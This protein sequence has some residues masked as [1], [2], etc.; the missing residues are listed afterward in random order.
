MGK[1][2]PVVSVLMVTYNREQYIDTALKSVL[3]QKTSFPFEIIICEDCSTDG[4]LAICE[5]YAKAYPEIIRLL[6]NEKNLGYQR[7]NLK[8]LSATRGKYIAVCDPDDYWICKDKLQ[9]QYDIMEKN[10]Q[11]SLCFHRVLNY[12]ENDGS[13]SLSNGTERKGIY[14]QLDLSKKNFIANVSCFF[15]NNYFELPEG[16]EQVVS[17]DYVFSMLSASK[18]DLYYIP[19][20]MALYRKSESSI[21]VGKDRSKALLMSLNVRKFIINLFPENK[22]VVDNLKMASAAILYNLWKL[23]KS[24]NETQKADEVWRELASEYPV[25]IQQRLISSES[26]AIKPLLKAQVFRL[27]S[28]IRK[29]LSKFYPLPI[30]R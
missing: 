24:E 21:F 12:Y 18:G 30:I 2:T 15:R 7:N 27:L 20:V 25:W 29:Q 23:H 14:T 5:K 22:E 17:V 26:I 28:L 1:E 13:K 10:P 19:K 16:I 4:T 8:C 3:R 11:Y 9:I 6:V